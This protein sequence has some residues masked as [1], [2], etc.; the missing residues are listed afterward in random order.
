[1]NRISSIAIAYKLFTGLFIFIMFQMCSQEAS[2]TGGTS[3]STIEVPEYIKQ[4]LAGPPA[5]SRAK[6][7]EIVKAYLSELLGAQI[8][9]LKKEEIEKHIPE[10]SSQWRDSIL[11]EVDVARPLAELPEFS[12]TNVLEAGIDEADVVKTDGNFIYSSWG[13]LLR[14]ILAYPPE[15][16]TIVAESRTSGEEILKLNDKVFSFAGRGYYWWWFERFCWNCYY[17]QSQ[18]ERFNFDGNNLNLEMSLRVEGMYD[19][20]R[21]FNEKIYIVGTSYLNLEI[22]DYIKYVKE[23]DVKKIVLSEGVDVSSFLPTIEILRYTADGTVSVEKKPIAECENIYISSVTDG[24]GVVW[25]LIMEP[26]GE[27]KRYAILGVSGLITN[28]YV[29]MSHTSL[30][31]L[32]SEWWWNTPNMKTTI[33]KLNIEGDEPIF[34]A[35]TQIEGLIP[36]LWGT[37]RNSLFSINEHNGMLRLALTTRVWGSKNPDNMIFIFNKNLEKIGEIRGIKPDEAIYAVRFFGDKAYI[38][39]FRQIDPLFIVDLSDP[40]NPHLSGELEVPGFSTYLH[41]V[42]DDKVFAIGREGQSL[43]A[44]LFDVSNPKSP[45]LIT[46]VYLPASW[47]ESEAE[48]NYKAITF[49]KNFV[50]LPFS[51]YEYNNYEYNNN[52]C[53]TSKNITGFFVLK[54]SDTINVI[55]EA[56]PEDFCLYN[57]FYNDYYKCYSTYQYCAS[58]LRA[59][60][61]GDFIYGVM[62]SGIKVWTA[63]LNK[64]ASLKLNQLLIEDT[65][66]R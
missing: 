66:F 48:W 36:S 47:S 53:Y 55:G 1:M 5:I 41:P 65:Y 19:S 15:G 12:E 3:T 30:Y 34:S 7:C 14:A 25:I 33:Y 28:P 21:I 62:S 40:Q 45:E 22:F 16:I 61:I 23:H 31:I 10:I 17:G 44:S 49:F 24:I 26:G 59:V 9:K 54:L 58:P 57:E 29:Y 8:E 39:T 51:K 63:N 52:S 11:S 35:G 2:K 56:V 43:Q 37:G 18:I 4:F 42:G 32:F 27:M 20:A 64:V 46:R 13:N 50:A 38:V 6:N 60:F